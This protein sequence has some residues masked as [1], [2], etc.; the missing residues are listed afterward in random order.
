MCLTITTRTGLC[1]GVPK[2]A[3]S[4]CTSVSTSTRTKPVFG[5]TVT[6]NDGSNEDGASEYPST[7]ARK[8]ARALVYDIRTIAAADPFKTPASTPESTQEGKA[9]ENGNKQE[10]SEDAIPSP[11]PFNEETSTPT[12]GDAAPKNIA[13][14]SS[15]A[16]SPDDMKDAPS[17]GPFSSASKAQKTASPKAESVTEIGQQ[18]GD[19]PDGYIPE[20][21]TTLSVPSFTLGGTVYTAA[22]TLTSD[23]GLGAYIYSG[24][25]GSGPAGTVETSASLSNATGV[26]AFTGRGSRSRLSAWVGYILLSTIV[27]VLR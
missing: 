23:Q 15:S 13:S 8:T 17:A 25:G 27:A 18:G 9:E 7:I 24:I 22:E 10:T 3:T 20:R 26:V 14:P 4:V 21:S 2:N 16:D 6:A 5:I 1:T 12:D 19:A 11:A